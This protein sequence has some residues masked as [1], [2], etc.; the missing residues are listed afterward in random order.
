MC[1]TLDPVLIFH[2]ELG[3]VQVLQD[4]EAG[5]QIVQFISNPH[6]KISVFTLVRVCFFFSS[7]VLCCIFLSFSKSPNSVI[8]PVCW[9]LRAIPSESGHGHMVWCVCI[10]LI[11][12][13]SLFNSSGRKTFKRFINVLLSGEPLCLNVQYGSDAFNSKVFC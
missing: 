4:F 8:P 7:C 13:S 1:F 12:N 10:L 5:L 2:Y 3:I 6:N 11:N 9:V